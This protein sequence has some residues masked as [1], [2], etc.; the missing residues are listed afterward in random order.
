MGG[1]MPYSRVRARNAIDWRPNRPDDTPYPP[2]D[3]VSPFWAP[4]WYLIVGDLNR[5]ETG[6]IA[7]ETPGVNVGARLEDSPLHRTARETGVDIE[8]VRKV[9]AYVFRGE[10]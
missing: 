9:L 5:M 1:W 2:D 7:P 6:Y 10:A 8:T 4:S 3:A